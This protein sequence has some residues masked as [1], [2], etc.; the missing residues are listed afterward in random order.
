MHS[1]VGEA[2]EVEPQALIAEPRA[3]SQPSKGKRIQG[4]GAN[5]DIEAR[6]AVRGFS[7]ALLL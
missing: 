5:K 6:E 2:L 3:K 7:R 1:G 4:G